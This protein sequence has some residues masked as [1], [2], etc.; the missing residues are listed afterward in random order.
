MTTTLTMDRAGRIMIP[1]ALRE[2]LRLNP[3]DTLELESKGETITLQPLRPKA[4]L[5]KEL[6]IWV[7]QGEPTHISIPDLIENHRNQRTKVILG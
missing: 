6:G 7:Y 5:K 1:K 3:G 4:L 2:N